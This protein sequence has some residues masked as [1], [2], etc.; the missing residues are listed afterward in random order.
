[1]E[2][3]DNVAHIS[4]L[5]DIHVAVRWHTSHA[6]YP[7]FTAL[8]IIT[9][10]SCEFDSWKTALRLAKLILPWMVRT[11]RPCAQAKTNL[12]GG[13]SALASVMRPSVSSS[14]SF[15]LLLA[16]AIITPSWLAPKSIGRAHLEIQLLMQIMSESENP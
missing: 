12:A 11:T 6:F 8:H 2:D 7:S 13:T 16:R 1:M 14:K 9:H 3:G 5:N 15:L 10:I 4:L